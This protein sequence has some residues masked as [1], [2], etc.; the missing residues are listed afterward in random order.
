[1]KAYI[2]DTEKFKVERIY[3]DRTR[4]NYDMSDNY[5]WEPNNRYKLF[6]DHHEAY[7]YWRLAKE[8]SGELHEG[9]GYNEDQLFD[10]FHDWLN[11]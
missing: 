2:I 8:E 10:M 9:L 6:H 5:A 7:D 11:D 3:D 1:M 4:A